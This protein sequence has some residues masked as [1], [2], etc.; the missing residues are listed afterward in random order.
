MVTVAG[1]GVALPPSLPQ[2]EL[3]DGYFARHYAGTASALARRI[4]ANSGVE[5]RHAAV[6]P[7]L[8]DVSG[9]PTAACGSGA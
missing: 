9:W 7:L 2:D 4:F 8:E 5:R 6:N 1:L 3:W